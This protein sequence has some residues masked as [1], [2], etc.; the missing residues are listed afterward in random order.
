MK[1][2]GKSNGMSKRQKYQTL[3]NDEKKIMALL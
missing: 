1:K 2:A 3:S